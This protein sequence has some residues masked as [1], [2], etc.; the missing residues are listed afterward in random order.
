MKNELYGA[1][2]E[3]MEEEKTEPN[4]VFARWLTIAPVSYLIGFVLLTQLISGDFHETLNQS[5]I[6]KELRVSY[7][8]ALGVLSVGTAWA[9]FT[10]ARIKIKIL[11][12]TTLIA[13]IL[14]IPALLIVKN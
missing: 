2:P 1:E 5:G 11:G 6:G 14:L 8:V 10:R 9:F 7:L 3:D 12:L 13:G 4:S